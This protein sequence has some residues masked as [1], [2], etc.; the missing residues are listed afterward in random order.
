M[1]KVVARITEDKVERY[2]V[3]DTETLSVDEVY[4][5]ELADYGFSEADC[6]DIATLY[7]AGEVGY[8]G[9]ADFIDTEYAWIL[10]VSYSGTL[11]YLRKKSEIDY[12]EMHA[13]FD[14]YMNPYYFALKLPATAGVYAELASFKNRIRG[15]FMLRGSD[16]VKLDIVGKT[17]SVCN[18]S[19]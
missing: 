9:I 11:N 7:C 14:R 5:N 4:T 12:G 15:E 10:E 2:V 19:G 16:A 1:R 13:I 8:C 17:I 6:A 3:A 18:G